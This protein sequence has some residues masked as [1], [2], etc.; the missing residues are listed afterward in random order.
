MMVNIFLLKNFFTPDLQKQQKNRRSSHAD[1]RLPSFNTYP[2]PVGYGLKRRFS[3]NF[4]QCLD[5]QPRPRL[6]K[7]SGELNI[8]MENVPKRKRR[9]LSDFFNTILDVKWRWH[10]IIFLLS[11]IISWFFFASI[12][13][14]IALIHGDLKWTLSFQD[15]ESAFNLM[16]NQTTNV[17]SIKERTP[18]V[19]GIHDFTSALLYS[20]E[21]QHTIGYGL[22]YITEECSFAIIFLMIQSC[23]GIF[24]QGLVAGK[25][26]HLTTTQ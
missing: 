17:S 4:Y 6:V 14:I 26:I 11:F 5:V 13:Y 9:L 22:R 19:Y 20:V 8:V 24:V 21:T 7:K 15:T 10:F 3:E 16:K 18:C 1:E 25:F 12:W 23:F 2:N